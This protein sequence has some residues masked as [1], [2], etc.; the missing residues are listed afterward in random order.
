MVNLFQWLTDPAHPG[1]KRGVAVVAFILSSLLSLADQG[2]GK[3]CE[4][5]LIEGNACAIHVGAYASWV[6]IVNEAIQTYAVPGVDFVAA[7]MG[8]WGLIHAK[9]RPPVTP[10]RPAFSR[11]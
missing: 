9:K 3:A 5:A 2:I 7:V 10:V 4:A 1:R 11:N 8:V 6:D